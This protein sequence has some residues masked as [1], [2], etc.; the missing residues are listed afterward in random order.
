MIAASRSL[1]GHSATSPAFPPDSGCPA[2]AASPRGTVPQAPRGI[3]A[4]HARRPATP[5]DIPA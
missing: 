1:R 5:Q 2:I 3:P 4:A